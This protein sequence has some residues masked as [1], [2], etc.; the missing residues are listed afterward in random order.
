MFALDSFKNDIASEMKKDIR[1]PRK[2]KGLSTNKLYL[3]C[4]GS[5]PLRD[6]GTIDEVL[7]SNMQVG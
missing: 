6:E 5:F 2:Q 7:N 4:H 1:V 3:P